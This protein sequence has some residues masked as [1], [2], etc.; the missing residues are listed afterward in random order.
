MS[1][2]TKTPPSQKNIPAQDSQV[3]DFAQVRSRKLDEKRKNT[4]RILFEQMLG[5]Y[6]MVE[7]DMAPIEIVDLLAEGCSFQV[8]SS[9]AGKWSTSLSEMVV[10]LYFSQNTYLPL[11]VSIQNRRDV[12]MEGRRLVRFGCKISTSQPA[13][14]AYAHFLG[15]VKLY[16]E[17]AL[18]DTGRVSLFY[19]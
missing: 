14:S 9:T 6:S 16:S 15:F 2:K 13:Y 3:I 11:N 18:K 12:I 5:I 8:P 1:Q 10:R 4:E 17:I 19:I 7:G